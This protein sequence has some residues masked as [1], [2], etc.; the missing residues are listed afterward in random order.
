M[1]DSSLYV[2]SRIS[3]WFTRCSFVENDHLLTEDQYKMTTTVAKATAF[4]GDNF[5]SCQQIWCYRYNIHNSRA[6]NSELSPC[7]HG[8]SY[9]SDFRSFIC[10]IWNIKSE[11]LRFVK[12]ASVPKN[13]FYKQVFSAN[14]KVNEELMKIMLQ[15]P[16]KPSTELACTESGSLN[17]KIELQSRKQSV[18]DVLSSFTDANFYEIS[19]VREFKRSTFCWRWA[20]KY[21]F[22]DHFRTIVVQFQ[23]SLLL[24]SYT[25]SLTQFFATFTDHLDF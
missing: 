9:I 11:N 1:R 4:I 25:S 6:H 21:R 10:K 17:V 2:F 19:R 23:F 15:T 8:T 5:S 3:V 18:F 22:F 12:H 14:D 20:L 7:I 24:K 13:N 16:T